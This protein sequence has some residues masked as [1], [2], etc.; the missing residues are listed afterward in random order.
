[1]EA[2]LRVGVTLEQCWHR[3]PGGTGR[4]TV[5]TVAA[6]ARRPD[7][8]VVGVAARHRAGARPALAPPVEVRH[9]RL[10]RRALY[11]GWHRLGR[12]RVTA[13]TGPLD[14]VWASAM[15]IPAA[16]VPLVATVHD[17]AFLDHPQWSTRRGL[18]FFRR[19]WEAT[20]R[21]ASL[22]VAP[23]AATAA[24]CARHG[25]PSDRVVVV[26]WGVDARPAGPDAVDAARRRWSLP[27]RFVL[28]VGTAE[29]RKNLP[30]LVAAMGRVDAPLVVVGP[31]GWRVDRAEV[32]APLGSRAVV[33]G[34]L[35]DDEL[36]AVYGAAT[37][38]AFPS[39]AEGF[40]LPVLEAMAQGTPVVTSRGT[41]TADAAGDA[42]VL[43]D[44]ADG[45]ALAAALARLLDDGAHRR[46][47]AAA[48][49]AR[50][51]AL[52][53]DATAAGYQ[54]ALRQAAAGGVRWR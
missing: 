19:S 43:V 16:E 25:L 51:A 7:L 36:R 46:A 17:L 38:F 53:W 15:A 37:V 6:L 49:R 35:A 24:D 4:A 31:D 45:E 21:R 27:E 20:M 8:E 2:L 22:V 23:S 44:P 3:V 5:A 33:L 34:P 39:H 54:R 50:A 18:S 42:A 29:P 41:G 14:V 1:V 30:G 28:W 47:L 10:P 13:V 12:P 11:E 9:H 26:P 52:T 48:G 40:G 32:L